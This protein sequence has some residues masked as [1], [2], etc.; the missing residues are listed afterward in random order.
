MPDGGRSS[1]TD[2]TRRLDLAVADGSL[3][4]GTA[5]RVRR[6]LTD[7]DYAGYAA[8][9]TALVL[10]ESFDEL[11]RLFWQVLPFGTG[12]RRGAMAELGTSTINPRTIAE[13]AHGLAVYL[14][15]LRGPGGRVA[16]AWDTRHRSEEFA[17]LAAATLVAHGL[18]V[19]FFD[20][21]RATPELSFAVRELDCDAGIVISASHNPPA[22]NGIKIYWTH[23]GQVLPPHDAEIIEAVGT[24]ATIPAG[25][26]DAARDSDRLTILEDDFD[27]M[28]YEA[29]LRT[30]FSDA[31]Q[32]DAIY[33]PL[34]GV[35]TRSILP[36]L[37]RAGFD[38]VRLFEP[39]AS[40][41]GS[42]PNVPDQLPNPERP[43]VF[44]PAIDEARRSGAALVLASDPDGD[45]LGVAARD[46][47][48]DFHVLTGNQLG[49]LLA[50]HVLEKR[51]ERGD[52]TPDHYVLETLVTTPLIATLARH[53]GVRA[54]DDLLVG[55]KHVA[56]TIEELGP[57]GFVF[58]AEE[59]LGYLAG[60]YC[61]DKDGA[62]AALLIA[63]AAAELDADGRSLFDRLDDLYQ[64]H[65]CV[66]EF[67]H[68][69][70]A[71][72]AEG[73]ARI[74]RLMQALRDD[75]PA[76]LDGIPLDRVRDYHR[77][78]IRGLPGNR[79]TAPLATPD[80]DLL[81]FETDHDGARISLAARPSGTEPKI[82]FYGFV[83]ETPGDG[84][85]DHRRRHTEQQL[86]RVRSGLETFL[87]EHLGDNR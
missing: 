75:P 5:E 8:R 66:A 54:I 15:R 77:H 60:T 78:E 7:P 42:F 53:H 14:N 40:P 38:G 72:G 22:D 29:V 3:V 64:A 63:E 84:E 37:E 57:G 39:Q 1:P 12:G 21:F 18:H 17:R 49:T 6:W 73:Q 58:A 61:R 24:A 59:S 33:T 47:N 28:Y 81:I 67:Q 76:D 50:D 74:A 48:G 25:D 56:R 51:R 69:V 34:H 2:A 71:E 13:S 23:G 11:E 26:F 10:D 87:V 9:V 30:G 68:A 65:G 41:D 83:D 4:P 35:G 62:G 82:K 32:L 44:G 70:V 46:R 80:G 36:V 45:R 43:E 52:L 86:A 31:R 79:P 16:V 20:G 85:L 19:L 55:F 27:S